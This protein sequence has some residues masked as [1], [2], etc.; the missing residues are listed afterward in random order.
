MK[1]HFKFNNEFFDQVVDISMGSSFFANVIG[2]FAM[3]EI[4]TSQRY[5]KIKKFKNLS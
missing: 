1:S 4:V 3:A 2:T 5:K